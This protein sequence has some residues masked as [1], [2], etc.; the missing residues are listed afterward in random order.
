MSCLLPTNFMHWQDKSVPFEELASS[1][2][3]NTFIDW[4]RDRTAT[5]NLSQRWPVQRER[6]HGHRRKNAGGACARDGD[7]DGDG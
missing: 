3:Q 7:G 5:E 2:T 4:Q 6:S 1:P